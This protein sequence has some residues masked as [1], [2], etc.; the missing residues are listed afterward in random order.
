MLVNSNV[1]VLLFRGILEKADK[2]FQMHSNNAVSKL[3][4]FQEL[5]PAWNKWFCKPFC[6]L[7]MALNCFSPWLS[8][9]DFGPPCEMCEDSPNF[10]ESDKFVVLDFCATLRFVELFSNGLLTVDD[11]GSAAFFIIRVV[12][13]GDFTTC[14]LLVGGVFRWVHS[15]SNLSPLDFELLLGEN[16]F[17]TGLDLMRP[18]TLRSSGSRRRTHSSS[19]SWVARPRCNLGELGTK[20]D[21]AF[22][23]NWGTRML[24]LLNLSPP[25]SFF[26]FALSPSFRWVLVPFNVLELLLPEHLACDCREL[27]LLACVVLCFWE[28]LLIFS[29]VRIFLL[30][31]EL[32]TKI[33]RSF[34]N[35]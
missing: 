12:W 17:L 24:M 35:L 27:L 7:V 13:E 16:V 29:C 28:G 21:F 6:F 3:F 30:L 11:T 18:L 25:G 9:S 34:L 20:D 26:F 8:V 23:P 14:F 4:I 5:V 19:K 10:I 33:N 32:E 22:S 31:S 1:R 15:T 2:I